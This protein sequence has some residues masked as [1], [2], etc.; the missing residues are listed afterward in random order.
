MANF[1][2]EIRSHI[3]LLDKQ[4]NFEEVTNKPLIVWIEPLLNS[5]TDD[6]AISYLLNKDKRFRAS[7][8]S[9]TLEWLNNSNFIPIN[10]IDT[11]QS[12]LIFLRDNNQPSDS[13]VGNT[14]KNL[15]MN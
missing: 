15:V 12:K 7:P 13:E 9:S 4:L 5:F 6:G 10:A 2:D 8:L 3:M 14:Q 1:K 11:I